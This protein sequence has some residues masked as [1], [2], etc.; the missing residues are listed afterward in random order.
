MTYS[1]RLILTKEGY[2][3]EEWK[4]YYPNEENEFHGMKEYTPER[5]DGAKQIFDN[6]IGKLIELGEQARKADK[7]KLFEI[8]VIALNELNDETKGL[9]IETDQREELCQ[10]IDN[11]SIQAGLKPEDYA[12]GYGI[13][14]IWREW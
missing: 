2:P 12:D 7:E 3:F 13:A 1:E 4:E 14:D 11:I 10:L 6:L 9:L 8:A 5:C